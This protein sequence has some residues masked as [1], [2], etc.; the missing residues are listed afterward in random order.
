[1][2]LIVDQA[3]LLEEAVDAHY[4]TDVATEVPPA[5]GEGEVFGR[6]ESVSVDHEVARVLVSGERLAAVPAIEPLGQVLLFDVV[7]R[8][9]VEP[10]AVAW[11]DDGVGL[12]DQVRP[13]SRL[14]R[15]PAQDHLVGG[16][17]AVLFAVH[18]VVFDMLRFFGVG[19]GLARTACSS[20]VGVFADAVFMLGDLHVLGVVNHGRVDVWMVSA[21]SGAREGWAAQRVA[22]GI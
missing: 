1:M 12:S 11:Q 14:E 10:L 22:A 2:Y 19:V 7:D 8:I 3:P 21:R 6:V 17:I 9:H 13:G 5:G 15:R 4:G 16:R 20:V 18:A